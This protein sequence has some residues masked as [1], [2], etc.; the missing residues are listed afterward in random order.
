MESSGSQRDTGAGNVG[1][2]RRDRAPGP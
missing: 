1:G 2:E